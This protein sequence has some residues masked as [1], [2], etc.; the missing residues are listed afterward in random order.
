MAEKEIPIIVVVGTAIAKHFLISSDLLKN[1]LIVPLKRFQ[2]HQL[3]ND[4]GIFD[5]KF[6]PLQPWVF[7]SGADGV[8]KLY[9]N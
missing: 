8:I 9:S 7:S 4:F 5:V 2:D 6:H 1:A 3:A